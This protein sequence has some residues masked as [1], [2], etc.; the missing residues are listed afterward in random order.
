MTRRVRTRVPTVWR[1]TI[2][3]DGRSVDEG[4]IDFGNYVND[5]NFYN[6]TLVSET[7]AYLIG[8]GE[9]IVWNPTTFEITGVAST[10][11]PT[12][13]SQETVTPP[14]R[15]TPSATT[16]RVGSACT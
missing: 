9:Y 10:T 2:D 3:D 1:F 13:C 4:I 6:Q 16:E 8:E 15:S 11:R 5:A 7:K 14:R 12:S